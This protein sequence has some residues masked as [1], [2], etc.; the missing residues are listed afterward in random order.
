MEITRLI[1]RRHSSSST[2]SSSSANSNTRRRRTQRF[3]HPTTTTH[4]CHPRFSR[5]VTFQL[6]RRRRRIPRRDRDRDRHRRI[7]RDLSRFTTLNRRGIRTSNIMRSST[8]PP[9]PRR[10]RRRHSSADRCT[11]PNIIWHHDRPLLNRRFMARSPPLQLSCLI[12]ITCST[13]PQR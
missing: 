3:I 4:T 2:S 12:I 8:S 9:P 13:T 7:L 6:I 10:R 5:T 1:P 11:W